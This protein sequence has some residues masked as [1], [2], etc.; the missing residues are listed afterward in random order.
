MRKV[1]RGRVYDTDTARR[2]LRVE[3]RIDPGDPRTWRC[4]SLFRKRT[5][6]YF[7]AGRGGAETRWADVSQAGGPMPGEGVVPVGYD[8]ARE[9]MEAHAGDGGCLGEFGVAAKASGSVV[10]YARVRASSKAVLDREA[11]RSGRTRGEIL[12]E[13]LAGL[14]GADGTP[15]DGT[16]R[17]GDQSRN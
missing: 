10:M 6:E 12:D 13:L 16:G 3:G 8:Q 1:I 17:A 9:W 2:V 5:G 11:A 14:G 7:I 4:E 15:P